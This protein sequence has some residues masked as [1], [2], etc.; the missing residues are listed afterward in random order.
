M[1]TVV[2]SV[3]NTDFVNKAISVQGLH[4]FYGGLEVLK[5][6]DF[7]AAEGEVVSIL[8]ASGSGK[9]TFLRCLNLLE[10]PSA[11]NLRIFGE[12]VHLKRGEINL[13]IGDRKQIDRLR[14]QVAM[15]FQNFCLWSHMT[16]LQNLMEA[17]VHVQ[18]RTK[19]EVREEAEAMLQRVGLQNHANHYPAQLSGGQQQRAAIARALVM[20]PRVLLFDEPTSALDPEL[21]GEVLKVMRDLAAEGRTMLIVTHEMAFARDVSS[22]ILFLE[23]GRVGAE[24]SPSELFGGGV[25]E[26]FAQ[27]ISRF[28]ES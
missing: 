12:Q 28:N 8:G 14:T 26:R 20:K 10:M 19:A 11:G 9:S 4:K 23:K 3:A 17:P 27:F 22:R 2:R 6:I 15:V 7:D 21:V 5:G 24:G 25:S 18:G 1:N 16:V 13:R